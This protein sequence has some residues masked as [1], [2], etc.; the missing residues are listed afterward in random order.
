[1]FGT[2]TCLH[3]TPVVHVILNVIEVEQVYQHNYLRVFF[4]PALTC[5]KQGDIIC[6][7]LAQRI[8]ILRWVRDYLDLRVATMMYKALI[9]PIFDYCNIIVG[10]GI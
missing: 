5:N 3:K 2:D 8:G 7:K 1:M 4:D 6:A 9:L 10:K